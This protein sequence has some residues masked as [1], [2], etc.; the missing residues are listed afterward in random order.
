MCSSWADRTMETEI[1][2]KQTQLHQRP[3]RRSE[4]NWE[5]Y[6]LPLGVY[7]QVEAEEKKGGCYMMA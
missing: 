6:G 2:K 4:E 3:V 5:M 7:R 1:V